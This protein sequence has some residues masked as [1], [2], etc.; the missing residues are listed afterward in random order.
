MCI[1]Y[2]TDDVARAMQEHCPEPSKKRS[3]AATYHEIA[4]LWCRDIRHCVWSL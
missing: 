1:Y 3:S 2:E 4:R